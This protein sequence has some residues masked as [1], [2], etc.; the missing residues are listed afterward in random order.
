MNINSAHQIWAVD[1]MV[2]KI[3]KYIMLHKTGVNL[4]WWN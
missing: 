3:K 2:D 1:R 4:L